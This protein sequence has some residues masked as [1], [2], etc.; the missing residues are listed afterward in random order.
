MWVRVTYRSVGI[1][2][3]TF[4]LKPHWHRYQLIK[5]AFLEPMLNLQADQETSKV[6]YTCTWE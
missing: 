1:S 2:E 5:A 4:S 3:A 6:F